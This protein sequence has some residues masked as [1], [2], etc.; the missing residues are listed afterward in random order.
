MTLMLPSGGSILD[1]LAMSSEANHGLEGSAP[2]MWMGAEPGEGN[3]KLVGGP[4][5]GPPVIWTNPRGR[6]QPCFMEKGN[7]HATSVPRFSG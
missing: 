3:E 5:R 6:K 7:G 2:C 1:G 4:E